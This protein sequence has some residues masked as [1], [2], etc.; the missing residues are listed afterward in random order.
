[1]NNLKSSV[2]RSDGS[3]S[4]EWRRSKVLESASHGLNQSEISRT[5]Q[6]SQPAINRDFVFL[7]Q[8][9]KQNIRKYID[10]R[11][12]IIFFTIVKAYNY[13]SVLPLYG[14]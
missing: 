5:L 12:T 9:A 7:R 14:R 11:L 3:S 1:M 6:I 2:N 13:T 8:Q 4:I 10:E